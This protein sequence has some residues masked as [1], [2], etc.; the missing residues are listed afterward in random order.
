MPLPNRIVPTRSWSTSTP[1]IPGTLYRIYSKSATT[2][3]LS[4][5]LFDDLTLIRTYDKRQKTH[6]VSPSALV[7]AIRQGPLGERAARWGEPSPASRRVPRDRDGRAVAPRPPHPLLHLQHNLEEPH[8][9]L[10]RRRRPFNR[11]PLVI[12]HIDN[13]IKGCVFGSS[14]KNTPLTCHF[15]ADLLYFPP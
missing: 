7:M 8:R 13:S 11:L 6:N 3:P 5:P 9:R 4:L 10:L 1:S 12:Q 15:A 14:H 2:L